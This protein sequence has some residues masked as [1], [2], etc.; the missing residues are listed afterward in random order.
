MLTRASFVLAALVLGAGCGRDRATPPAPEATGAP[1]PAPVPAPAP[2]PA[3]GNDPV[4]R[5]RALSQEARRDTSLEKS[6]DRFD[7]NG[8][9]NV[10]VL[11]HR[12]DGAVRTAEVVVA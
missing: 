3:T 8:E 5:I 9:G 1:A 11:R 6:E 10:Q 4:T 12:K 7:C 2:A